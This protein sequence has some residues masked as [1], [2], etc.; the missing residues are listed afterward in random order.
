MNSIG[1]VCVVIRGKINS[2]NQDVAVYNLKLISSSSLGY[3]DCFL[4]R[5]TAVSL[6]VKE[7]IAHNSN[8]G[9]KRLYFMGFFCGYGLF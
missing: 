5:Q 3:G 1:F 7:Q 6:T 2:E 4:Y 9:G 8:R